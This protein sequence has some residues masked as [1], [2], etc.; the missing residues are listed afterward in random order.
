MLW[1]SGGFVC[2]LLRFVTIGMARGPGRQDPQ[3]PSGRHREVC[4]LFTPP[5]LD[6]FFDTPFPVFLGRVQPVQLPAPI[7]ANPESGTDGTGQEVV[8]VA[9]RAVADRWG[10]CGHCGSVGDSVIVPY[11]R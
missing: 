7:G 2:V 4:F 3:A 5:L 8:G 11:G 10:D 1:V 6:K 9:L